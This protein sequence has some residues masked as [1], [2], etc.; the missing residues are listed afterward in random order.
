MRPLVVQEFVTLDGVVQAPGDASEYSHG[1]WQL[2]FIG[3]EQ[4]DIITQQ[5]MDADALVLGRRTYEMFAAAWPSRTGLRGLAERMNS[6]PK[7]VASGSLTHVSWNATL[8]SGDVA[9]A[10]RQLTDQAGN[11]LLILGST[12][13]VRYLEALQLIDEYRLWIHP[14]VVGDGERLF[15][16][17]GAPSHWQ[18]SDYTVLPTG[19]IVTTYQRA[20]TNE[21]QVS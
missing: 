2:P 18:L 17:S 19:V 8:L 1:G 15:D 4:L 7:F 3:D 10:L 5:I 13:L 11:G 14:V 6:I 9:T 21:V 16:A 20:N 12:T